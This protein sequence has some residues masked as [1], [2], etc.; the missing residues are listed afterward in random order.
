MIV[1]FFF[2][3]LPIYFGVSGYVKVAQNVRKISD[4]IG[5]SIEAGKIIVIEGLR[6]PFNIKYRSKCAILDLQ[7]GMCGFTDGIY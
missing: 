2:E 1:K 4:P 7:I 6:L 3:K 5:T